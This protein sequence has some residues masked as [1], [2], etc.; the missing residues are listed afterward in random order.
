[1]SAGTRIPF[2]DGLAIAVDIIRLL[3][4]SYQRIAVAGSIRRGRADVGDVEILLIPNKRWHARTDE[5]VTRGVL[6]KR[7]V[8][9]AG[10]K[11][12]PRWGEKLRWAAHTASGA[13]VDFYTADALNWGYQSILRT[14][15]GEAN[16][17][18]V[19]VDGVKNRNG[20]VGILPRNLIFNGGRLWKLPRPVAQR[21]AGDMTIPVGS[22]EIPTPEEEDVFAAVGLPWLP[23]DARSVALY[24]HYAR[25]HWADTP[26]ERFATGHNRNFDADGRYRGIPRDAISVQGRPFW[27]NV[28]AGVGDD[29][30]EPAQE[31]M[32]GTMLL[33]SVR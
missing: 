32:F 26:G 4:G 27:P 21:Y 19:T 18:L 29:E 31:R 1:M 25:A 5:L 13:N 6:A 9:S 22:V 16:D 7:L 17:T 10:G 12:L 8:N 15:P 23:P 11:Q 33:E 30:A 14:G 24:Q 2:A 28:P 3:E 20:H